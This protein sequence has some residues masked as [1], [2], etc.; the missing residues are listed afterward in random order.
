MKYILFAAALFLFISCALD[1]SDP[2]AN[3]N[4]QADNQNDAGGLYSNDGPISGGNVCSPPIH[5][6]ID[7]KE[8]VQPMLCPYPHPL[9]ME[10]PELNPIENHNLLKEQVH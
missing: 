5:L 4:I 10:P 7:G 3:D 2:T 9:E 1:S 8:Y 6:T